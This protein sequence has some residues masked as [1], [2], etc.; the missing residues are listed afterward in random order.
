MYDELEGMEEVVAYF[1]VLASIH[2]GWVI[3]WGLVY[4]NL[5]HNILLLKNK[6]YGAI[7]L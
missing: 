4:R 2:Q 3:M 7:I 5:V 1:I 6:L